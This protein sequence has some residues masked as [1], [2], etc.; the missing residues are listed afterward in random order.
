[1]E[2]SGREILE[3]FPLSLKGFFPLSSLLCKGEACPSLWGGGSAGGQP[4]LFRVGAVLAG[5]ALPAGM[6]AVDQCLQELRA[7]L[8]EQRGEAV[9]IQPCGTA[10][11]L[12]S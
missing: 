12:G 11:L 8:R 2:F 9:P 10:A 7:G 5:S 1:M 4:C 6:Q 3:C